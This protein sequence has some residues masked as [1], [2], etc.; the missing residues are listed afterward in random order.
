MFGFLGCK[1]FSDMMLRLSS[2]FCERGEQASNVFVSSVSGT[3][4]ARWRAQL[5]GKV[6]ARAWR[7]DGTGRYGILEQLSLQVVN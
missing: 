7:V 4:I 6:F 1:D 5:F 3:T 2:R